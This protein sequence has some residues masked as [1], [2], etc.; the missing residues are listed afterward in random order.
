MFYKPR[1]HQRS[2][3][4]LQ[5]LPYGAVTGLERGLILGLNDV[6]DDELISEMD[7]F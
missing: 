3:T 1:G 5:I 7:S 6:D 2:V 4:P